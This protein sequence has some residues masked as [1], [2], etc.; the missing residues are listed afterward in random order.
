MKR[1]WFAWCA[2]VFGLSLASEARA[3]ALGL[4][5][6]EYRRTDQGLSAELTFAKRE[7]AALLRTSGAGR[8]GIA[9]ERAALQDLVVRRIRV[10]SPRGPC[11]GTLE[12]VHPVEGDGVVLSARYACPGDGTTS[13]R[14]RLE[15]LTALAHGHRHAARIVSGT[16][17]AHALHFGS[18][19]SAEVPALTASAT[20]DRPSSLPGFA[21][22]GVEHILSGYDHLLF[23]FALLIVARRPSDL[24]KVVSA[25]TVA[26]SLTLAASVLGVIAPEPRFVEPAIALSVAYV[27][28]E[29]FFVRDAGRRWRV[30]LC[31]GLLHGFGFAG[32]LG[33]I[34]LPRAELLPA[35]L[36]FN[37][38]VE[39]GQL[40]VIALAAPLVARLARRAWFDARVVPALSALVIGV[41]VGWF[42]ERVRDDLGAS[43]EIVGPVLRKG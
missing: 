35:L 4:S 40:L 37:L 17:V 14:V 16:H 38:G 34:A 15:V 12:R 5:Q 11:A 42:A 25:F 19:A 28:L 18:N 1:A 8:A 23:L 9:T 7:L 3:H 32:V 13:L 30:A 33:E 29:N 27:G 26:H 10:S 31:F 22:L 43:A 6:G 21:L 24:V 20:P 41:G 36:A 2:C 39:L